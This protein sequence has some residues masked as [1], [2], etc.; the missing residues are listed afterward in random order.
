MEETFLAAYIAYAGYDPTRAS[1]ATWLT[2][3]AHNK[4]VNLVRSAS[5]RMEQPLPDDETIATAAYD[6]QIEV[7]ETVRWLYS[8]LTLG[9]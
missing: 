6:S 8:K 7:R 4:A 1:L 2:R 5:Y 9:R 3:I